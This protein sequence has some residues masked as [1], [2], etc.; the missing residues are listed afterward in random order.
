MLVVAATAAADRFLLRPAHGTVV[1]RA[2]GL[3]MLP[4]VAVHLVLFFSM[5]WPI[6]L[7][8][9]LLATVI[10]FPLAY[11]FELAG[12]TIWAPSILHFVIQ[13]GVKVIVLPHGAESFAIVWMAASAMVPLLVFGFKARGVA[14]PRLDVMP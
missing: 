8:S 10:S 12:G 7:A 11:L 4:I 6:A 5:P 2:A 9:A 14:E 3:S 1:W 13:A